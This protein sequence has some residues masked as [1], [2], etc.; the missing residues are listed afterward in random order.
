MR[1]ITIAVL[2]TALLLSGCGAASSAT[3]EIRRQYGLIETA[4]MEAEVTFHADGE[5]R[6]FTLQCDYT[7]SAAAVTVTAP[8]QVAGV[9]ATLTGEELKLTY[10][11]ESLSVGAVDGVNPLSALPMLLRAVAQGYLLEESSETLHD[12]VCRRLL[13]DTS[14]DGSGPVYVVWIE[15]S[16]Y[17]PRWGECC[18][19]GETVITVEMLAFSCTLQEA[20]TE[21]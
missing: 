9:S 6:V 4:Q 8:E 3:E 14:E 1:K 5:E 11:G 15:E 7:P 21:E 20:V 13:L 16:T 2:L 19:N 10:G 17:L 18:I 12:T